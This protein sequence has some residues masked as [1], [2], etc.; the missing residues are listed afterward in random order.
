MNIQ[1]FQRYSQPELSRA[2]D[3]LATLREETESL[4][5]TPFSPFFPDLSFIQ[6]LV[7]RRRR[8]RRQRPVHSCR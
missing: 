8:L 2:F 1:R 5:N 3:R 4:F 7:S 6:H